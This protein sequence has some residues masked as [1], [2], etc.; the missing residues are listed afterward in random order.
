MTSAASRINHPKKRP[1]RRVAASALSS[2]HPAMK[3]TLVFASLL[4]LLAA[5]GRP[6]EKLVGSF[7]DPDKTVHVNVGDTFFIDLPLDADREHSWRMDLDGNNEVLHSMAARDERDAG[8]PE[9]RGTTHW[10]FFA[11][12]PGQLKVTFTRKIDKE[13]S[14]S[15]TFTVAIKGR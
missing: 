3:L 13:K 11:N 12:Q 6:P 4:T 14:R 15:M 7:T 8:E 2:Y 1:A 9:T 5:C 10:K